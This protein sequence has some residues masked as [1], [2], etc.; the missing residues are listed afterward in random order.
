MEALAFAGAA[1]RL[2]LRLQDQMPLHGGLHPDLGD[3]GGRLPA[4]VHQA[5]G[6][7]SVPASD[8]PIRSCC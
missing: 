7:V 5:T 1:A 2:L 4:E 6:M 3:R 8:W